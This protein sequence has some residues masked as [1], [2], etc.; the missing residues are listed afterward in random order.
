ML[1]GGQ[2]PRADLVDDPTDRLLRLDVRLDC[3]DAVPGADV[4]KDL[5]CGRLVAHDGEDVALGA[6]STDDGGDAYVAGG[7]KDKDG[8]GHFGWGFGVL[9]LWWS[10]T[11]VF[12]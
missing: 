9:L 4:L 6:Q 7:A 12:V 2:L 8:F 10:V 3:G 11:E 1:E 5:L